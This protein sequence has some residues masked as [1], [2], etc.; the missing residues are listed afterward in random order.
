MTARHLSSVPSEPL[1]DYPISAAENLDSHYFLQ[2]NLKR[3]RGSAFKKTCDP[4]VG[5]YGFNLF[6]IAQDGRPVGTLPDDPS[7]LAFDLHLSVDKFEDLCRLNPSPLHGWYRVRCD[8]G[9]IRL[10]HKVVTECVQEALKGKRDNA[11]KNADDR[12]RKRLRT[13]AGHVYA[14]TGS[15]RLAKDEERLNAV[16]DWIE[17]TYPGGSATEK[18]VREAINALSR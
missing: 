11:A 3:W 14:I 17:T 15:D 5:W 18:R 12:M 6:C 2:W 10:A 1:P 16:H 4:V 13:I 8:N 9:E 7:Q